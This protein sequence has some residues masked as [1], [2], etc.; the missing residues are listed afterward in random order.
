MVDICTHVSP[1]LRYFRHSKVCLLS[2][3]VTAVNE[4]II[5]ILIEIISMRTKFYEILIATKRLVFKSNLLRCKCLLS[6][7]FHF[8]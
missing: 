5:M 7:M 1:L 3:F 8:W 6:E 2:Y 4:I